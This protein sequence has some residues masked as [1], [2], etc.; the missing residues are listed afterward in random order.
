MTDLRNAF[1]DATRLRD[2]R[3][4]VHM[5]IYRGREILDDPMVL[6]GLN[7]WLGSCAQT[8]RGEGPL[9]LACD[10]EFSAADMPKGFA[11]ARPPIGHQQLMIATGICGN[12][13]ERHSDNELMRIAVKGMGIN[14]DNS[15][16]HSPAEKT[17]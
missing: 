5:N 11:V 15:T 13:I 2:G 3:V 12:C 9:C 14:V 8:K 4:S 10:F 17:Q 6:P 7:E 1:C 16:I